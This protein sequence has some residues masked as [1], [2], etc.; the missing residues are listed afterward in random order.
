MRLLLENVNPGRDPRSASL[1]L[2]SPFVVASDA[3]RNSET[4]AASRREKYQQTTDER[5]TEGR[6]VNFYWK[7]NFLKSVRAKGEFGTD[8]Y[9]KCNLIQRAGNFVDEAIG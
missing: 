9:E 8:V 7:E 5:K 3:K 6:F 2:S 4:S 1:P